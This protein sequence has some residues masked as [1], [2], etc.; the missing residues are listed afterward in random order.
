MPL[1][2]GFF[3][4]V[5]KR[6]MPSP[7]PVYMVPVLSASHIMDLFSILFHFSAV[8]DITSSWQCW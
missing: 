6:R 7:E 8:E 3:H 1:P 5:C 4:G 2:E